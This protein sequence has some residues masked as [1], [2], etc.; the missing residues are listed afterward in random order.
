M[1]CLPRLHFGVPWKDGEAERAAGGRISEFRNT[2]VSNQLGPLQGALSRDQLR[3]MR[4]PSP[5][6]LRSAC[7]ASAR[8]GKMLHPC[9]CAELERFSGGSG[10]TS[11]F[12]FLA[13]CQYVSSPHVAASVP[14]KSDTGAPAYH[15]SPSPLHNFRQFP[16]AAPKSELM[17]NRSEP[18]PTCLSRWYI[19]RLRP[20]PAHRRRRNRERGT[21]AAPTALQPEVSVARSRVSGCLCQPETS[22]MDIEA[23]FRFAIMAVYQ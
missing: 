3:N 23:G 21:S 11:D 5:I 13:I 20:C 12:D 16:P 18:V 4:R 22:G 9:S 14:Q 1:C 10:A 15:R 7:A 6:A 19:E 17:N 8:H 2:R